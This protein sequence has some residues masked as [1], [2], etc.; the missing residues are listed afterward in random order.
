[1]SLPYVR[2]PTAKASD[3][4][5]WLQDMN[6][7]AEAFF[8]AL[9][10]FVLGWADVERS[11]S[12]LIAHY[13]RV[14][15]PVAR[16]LFSGSRARTMLAQITAIAENTRM[17]G[18]RKADIA[19]LTAK[20]SAL[21]TN[22]DRIAHYG[23]LRSH[24]MQGT[25]LRRRVSNEHRSS[26]KT[27]HFVDFFGSEELEHFAGECLRICAALECHMKAGR[28]RQYYWPERKPSKSNTAE[29]PQTKTK[30]QASRAG[31]A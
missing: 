7:E 31:A 8:A 9:G 18:A 17:P 19:F 20:I 22:R 25:S 13:A 29:K 21:N 11:V 30:S 5:Q 14:S 1:M 15:E 28:F 12:E 27:K 4:D 24:T 10:R 3:S 6:A 2:V 23:S 16:A 26:R